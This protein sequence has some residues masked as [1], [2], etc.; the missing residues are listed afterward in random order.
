MKK[1]NFKHLYDDSYFEDRNLV[2][3]KRINSFQQEVF[4]INKY[5]KNGCICDVG[6]ST[7]EFLREIKWPGERFGMEINDNAK[8]LAK[9]CGVRFDKDI[10]NQE[11]FFDIVVFRGVI[12]HLPNPFFYIQNA[13]KSLKP[14]GFIVFLAT[15]NMNS[16]YY[17]LFNDL[18][19]LE[20]K[21][22]FYIPS[23]KTL[24]NILM[25]F[26]FKVIETE[27]PYNKSPYANLLSDHYKFIKKVLFKTEDTF[28]FWGNSMNIIAQKPL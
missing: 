6:C 10:L 8:K 25:N 9:D 3:K 27:K 18:P 26:N 15:P 2:D 28:A 14:G 17:K 16:I 19:M 5:I 1:E 12:Q 13:Y 21:L 11:L 24:K 7:G 22:N 23:D 20:N 4:F